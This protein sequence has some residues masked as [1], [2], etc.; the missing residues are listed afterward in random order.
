MTTHQ[1]EQL[2]EALMYYLPM[3]IRRR[4]ASELPEAY[5]A[6]CRVQRAV[7]KMDLEAYEEAKVR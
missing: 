2:L 4:I 3:D 1:R 5:E 6:Y 7:S